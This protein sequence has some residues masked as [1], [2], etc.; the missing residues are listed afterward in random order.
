MK[1]YI[2]KGMVLLDGSDKTG[3][4]VSNMITGVTN[5]TVYPKYKAAKEAADSLVS[6]LTNRFNY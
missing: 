2:I 3:W 4:Q 6:F 5:P 1:T